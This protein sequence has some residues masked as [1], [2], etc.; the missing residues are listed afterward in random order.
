[1]RLSGAVLLPMAAALGAC[2]LLIPKYPLRPT[3]AVQTEAQAIA[4][5]REHCQREPDAPH[6]W[7]AHRN[8]DEWFVDWGHG[9][10]TIHAEIMKSDGSF[11]AC[12][13]DLVPRR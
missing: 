6:H 2:T 13:V 12:D 5:A 3:D 8:R 10:S 4:L 7:T 1:M 11:L 9:L